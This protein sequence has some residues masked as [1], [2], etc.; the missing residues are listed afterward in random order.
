MGMSSKIK[1]PIR[2][3]KQMSIGGIISGQVNDE[4]DMKRPQHI[5]AAHNII[6]VKDIERRM[7]ID[8]SKK[9]KLKRAEPVKEIGVPKTTK[10]G[11]F[12]GLDVSLLESIDAS[13]TEEKRPA[14]TT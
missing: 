8:T 5:I 14:D 2:K 3:I 12:Y 10:S 6:P 9:I 13:I 11:T 7:T 4:H 1:L